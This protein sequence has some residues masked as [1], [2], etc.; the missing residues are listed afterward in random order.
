M[1]I[2]TSHT[3]RE[4]VRIYTTVSHQLVFDRLETLRATLRL[5]CYP[6]VDS[7]RMAEHMVRYESVMTRIGHPRPDH[8]M[9]TTRMAFA[10]VAFEELPVIDDPDGLP[11]PTSGETR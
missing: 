11:T 3:G 2:D 10:A 8:A 5:G 7:Y 6:N 1:L 4:D 9:T